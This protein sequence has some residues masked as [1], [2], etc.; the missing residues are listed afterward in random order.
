MF[1]TQRNG[2]QE[3]IRAAL[4]GVVDGKIT[5][6]SGSID[7]RDPSAEGSVIVLNIPQLGLAGTSGERDGSPLLLKLIA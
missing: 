2:P 1:F 7:P 3:Q 4:V 6:A 5:G